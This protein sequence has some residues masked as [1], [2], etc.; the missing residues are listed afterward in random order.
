MP[1]RP[2]EVFQF[3]L[4]CG[5]G[6]VLVRLEQIPKRGRAEPFRATPVASRDESYQVV[7]ERIRRIQ[8]GAPELFDAVRGTGTSEL[9]RLKRQRVLA[10]P[11]VPFGEKLQ[12]LRR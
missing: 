1:R 8:A 2:L 12:P 4:T 9:R 3:A 10:P 6:D 7:A 5:E 11:V